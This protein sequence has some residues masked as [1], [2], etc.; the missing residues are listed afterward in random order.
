MDLKLKKL[1]DD[2]KHNFS[3]W[4]KIRFDY[5]KHTSENLIL[6]YDKNNIIVQQFTS[7]LCN[8]LKIFSKF[9]RFKDNW[10]DPMYSLTIGIT[11]EIESEKTGCKYELYSGSE[12][13]Y[14]QSSLIYND[15]LKKM[16]DEF[17][18]SVLK[19]ANYGKF[20]FIENNLLSTKKS[21]QYK[22]FFRFDHS[23]LFNL[24]RNYILLDINNE[25]SI[26]FG[27]LSIKWG[28]NISI[29]QLLI[30]GCQAFKS[31]YKIDYLLYKANGSKLF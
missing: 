19:L 15:N 2:N 8:F 12:G 31:L 18:E 28:K 14:L 5:L 30:N 20:E 22:Q 3:K 11:A 1:I 23:N 26:D 9:G 6:S 21:D 13:F 24:L 17:W 7:I 29:E 27:F 16:N 10:S 4:D 25:S